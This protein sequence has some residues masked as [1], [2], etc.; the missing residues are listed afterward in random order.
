[1]QLNA[2]P[3][4]LDVT[5]AYPWQ[6]EVRIRVVSSPAE[7]WG[8]ALRQPAWCQHAAVTGTHVT[9]NGYLRSRRTWAP[10]DEITLTLDMPVQVIAAHPA[11]DAVRGCVALQRGPIVYCLEQQD[12]LQVIDLR[13]PIEVSTQAD[14]TVT[15]TGRGTSDA[16][17]DW[18]DQ[19]YRPANDA[20]PQETPVRWVATPYYRWANRG[21]SPMR[22]W[23]PAAEGPQ[24]DEP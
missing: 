10:G 20:K 23:L 1:V 8:L 5:T 13:S 9:Q 19:L 7:P 24:R 11:V 18:Q 15:L 17:Q 21:V 12:Q 16:A 6:G 3:V 2:G 22:V 4:E 14:G